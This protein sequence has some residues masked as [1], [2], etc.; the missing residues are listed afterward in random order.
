[1]HVAAAS[2]LNQG[3]ISI[4]P[5]WSIGVSQDRPIMTGLPKRHS[6]FKSEVASRYERTMARDGADRLAEA[7]RKREAS[8]AAQQKESHEWLPGGRRDLDRQEKPSRAGIAVELIGNQW[9]CAE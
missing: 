4:S 1:M 2:V 9:L 5:L 6:K 7:A 3:F 8:E